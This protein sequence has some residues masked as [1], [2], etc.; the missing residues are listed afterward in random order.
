MSGRNALAM[1]LASFVFVSCNKTPTPSAETHSIGIDL[2][3]MDKSVNP[4]DDFYEY[5]NGTWLKST[6]IPADKSRYGIFTKMADDTRE[7]TVSIIQDASK[8]GDAADDARKVGDYYSSFMDEAGIEAKGLTPLKAQLDEI[9]GI[10]DKKI[11]SRAIGQTLRADVDPLNDTNFETENLFGIWITQ[12]LEDPDHNIPYLLQGGLGLPDRDYYLSKDPHMVD[13]RKQY[14]SHVAAVFKLAGLSGTEMRAARVF[15]L[16]TKIAGF[17]ATR[18]ESEDVHSAV[19][20]KREEFPAK[21]PGID[22]PTLL[23]AAGLNDV[24]AIIVWHPKAVA[25]LAHL[26]ESEPI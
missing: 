23:Q 10:S 7:R 25:G 24:P 9:A 8:S 22:W 21:A 2:A 18:V 1:L 12:G 20:W 5:T 26:V 19:L 6:A 3:G 4:G 15:S 11:L 16:E 13:L 14:Q 17:H